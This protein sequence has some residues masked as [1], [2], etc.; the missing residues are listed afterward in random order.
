MSLSVANE[1]HLEPRRD[2]AP[3]RAQDSEQPIKIALL[4][5]GSD[6]PYALGLTAALGAEGVLIDFIGSD[7]LS[8]PAIRN[9]AWV[10]F[11][12]LRGDQSR[13]AA[14]PRKV[15]RILRYYLRLMRYAMVSRS[16]VF[17]ILWNNRFEAFDRTVLMLYYRLLGRRIV[18]TAHNVNARK[19]DLR[20][21]YLNRLTLW[22]QY[23]LVHHIFVHTK[24]MKAE[25]LEDFG[26]PDTKVSVIPLG[27]N[28][29]VPTTA[30]TV[31]E[32]KRRLGIKAE[33]RTVLFFGRIAPY[34]GLEYL[35]AAVAELAR[36]NPNYRL[37][38]AGSIKDCEE[39]WRQIQSDI[40]RSG[41]QARFSQYIDFIP[42][43]ETEFYFKAADVSV[44]PY[45]D[46]FQSGVLVLAYSFGLP[47][48]ATDVGSLREEI[49]EGRT[50]YV[51]RPKDALDLSAAIER[52]FSSPL[53][54]ELESR[55]DEIR[56]YANGKYSW[57]KVGAIT[58]DV[59]R[60][61]LGP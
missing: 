47:V 28:N 25:L 51:C 3:T 33:D 55:R 30:L 57:S 15:G 39:Y 61:V 29:T 16:R 44:L 20:D 34:K 53:F 50:G 35:V 45:T 7:D 17:H 56:N 21:S 23:K 4:T 46:I 48:I 40:S 10:N 41:V 24:K 5:G 37:I 2:A 38:I 58:T 26:V 11:L 59:Y 60:S 54:V 43:E 42:D 22:L 19:R 8:V 14:F 6:K 12:N 49:V 9:A 27:V 31:T 13:N 52:Y 1:R 36:R 32:A 18:F